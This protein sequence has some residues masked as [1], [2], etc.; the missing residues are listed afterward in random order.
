MTLLI[1]IPYR[2]DSDFA[3]GQEGVENIKYNA[4]ADYQDVELP[5][6]CK[7]PLANNQYLFILHNESATSKAELYLDTFE[8]LGGHKLSNVALAGIVATSQENRK[9]P[10]RL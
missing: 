10:T 6:Y 3:V 8:L 5:S 4:N 9:H 7:W 2:H 1:L